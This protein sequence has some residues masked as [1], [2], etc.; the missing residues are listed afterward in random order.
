MRRSEVPAPR[1]DAPSAPGRAV[2]AS[3]SSGV[4]L[5]RNRLDAVTAGLLLHG[6]DVPGGRRRDRRRGALAGALPR[7]WSSAR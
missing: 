4:A 7:S 1:A 6:L 3:R 2:A 5:G